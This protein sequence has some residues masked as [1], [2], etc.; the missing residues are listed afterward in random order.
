[1]SKTLIKATIIVTLLLLNLTTTSETEQNSEN[2]TNSQQPSQESNDLNIRNVLVFI[3][4]GG[5]SHNF[6][7][8]NLFEYTNNRAI[9]EEKQFKYAF[10]ILVHNFD[11]PIWADSGHKVY[12]YGDENLYKEKFFDAMEE[13]KNDPIMGYMGF[14]NAMKHLYNDF[15]NEADLLPILK[16]IKFEVII[17]DIANLLNIF[18]ARELNIPKKIYVNPTCVYSWLNTLIEYNPAY[19]PS[20]GTSLTEDMNFLGRFTNFFLVHGTNLFYDFFNSD[21]NTVF[22]R[23]GYPEPINPFEKRAFYMNQCVEGFH[24]S[25]PLPSNFV[26]LG[27]IMPKP[28]QPLKHKV[29]LD[30]MSQYDSIIYVSQGTI[31]KVFRLEMFLNTFNDFES[32]GFIMS[33]SNLFDLSS[34]NIPKN[35]LILDWVP[36]NDLLGDAKVKA[37]ITHGGLNSI[38][39]SLYHGKPMIAIGF[40]LDQTNGAAAVGYRKAGISITEEK[41]FNKENL[42]A[43]IVKILSEKIYKENCERISKYVKVKDGKK[44]FYFWLNYVF[45]VG[46]EHLLV[47]P[48][49]SYSHFQKYNLDIMLF[50]FVIIC[51]LVYVVKKIFFRIYDKV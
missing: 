33:K 29:I 24:Y 45:E 34:L 3:F 38:L 36:Q 2:I 7:F 41:N 12:G 44:T 23:N 27:A 1:M 25:I 30:F 47:K 46:Y 5:K 32:I 40:S 11:L 6:V 9:K 14:N 48:Y 20:I 13:A 50:F 42:H 17:S 37:F 4:P 22:Q 18:L 19:S 26:N 43:S 10:Y 16:K 8:K 15:L 28:A 49:L 21:Q 51:V 31:T 35:V 39:E